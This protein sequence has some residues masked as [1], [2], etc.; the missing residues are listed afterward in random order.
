M[1]KIGELNELKV[2]R[3]TDIGYMLTDG[4][5]EVLLHNNE[6][7]FKKLEAGQTVETF[8]YYDHKARLAATL[9]KP[10]ITTKR[11]GF[12]VV[13]DLHPTLGV[14]VDNGTSKDMLVSNDFLPYDQSLWP[15][16]GDKLYCILRHKNRLTAKPLNKV[17]IDLSPENKLNLGDKVIAYVIHSGKE[18]LNMLTE[19]GHKIFVHHTQMRKPHRMGEKLEVRIARLTPGDYSGSLI[20]TKEIMMDKDAEMIQAYLIKHGKMPLTADSDK[21]AIDE[22]FGLSKK[23]FKRALGRLYS[24]RKV[25]FENG[26]TIWIKGE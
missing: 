4:T 17:D 25:V 14:F 5:D 2:L 26:E 24:E 23:A 10:I 19:D 13:K 6:T 16:I 15:E 3:K 1:L 22:Q 7:N 11:P 12:V 9:S 21:E 20:E 8:I 18:G